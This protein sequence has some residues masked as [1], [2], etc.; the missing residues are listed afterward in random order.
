MEE[1]SFSFL[2][3]SLLYIAGK[4]RKRWQR[5]QEERAAGAKEKEAVRQE[6]VAPFYAQAREA[7][8]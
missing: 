1:A 6:V 2:P 5:Q 7:G 4:K 8:R 3:A